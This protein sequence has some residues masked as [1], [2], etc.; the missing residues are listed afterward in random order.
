MNN[1][2]LQQAAEYLRL[3]LPLMARNRVPV[4][5]ENY[6]VWYA[7]VVGANHGLRL[8][9]D[10]IL[11][12]GEGVDERATTMLYQRFLVPW[13]EARAVAAQEALSKTIAG[14]QGSVDNADGDASRYQSAL[15][16]YT[17]QITSDIDSEALRGL[18][19]NLAEETAA[20]R[21][22]GE[23]LRDRLVRSRREIERLR[24]E[25]DRA[26]DEANNDPLTGLLNRQGLDRAFAALPPAAPPAS[27]L[28]IDL[29]RFKRVNNN[30]GHLVGD[31]VLKHIAR[32]LRAGIKG[33]DI[34]AR[35]GGE[36]FVVVLPETPLGGAVTLAENL[37][38]K[39]HHTRLMR[40]EDKRPIGEV[41][42]S[43]GV[44]LRRSDEDLEALIGRADAALYT[45]KRGGR[46]RV[47]SEARCAAAA[48]APAAAPA[49]A[50][51]T[52][53]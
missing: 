34:A 2:T 37:R 18:L 3:T 43:I 1:K 33:G 52:E 46:N 39:I 36:E 14:V 13:D 48:I 27:L 23:H 11:D 15:A 26:H 12:Q 5:P 22:S 30:C 20:M 29:D 45:A 42:V 8:A 41:T 49:I 38:A 9:L 10:E 4:T 53:G 24:E 44:A 21:A 47:V 28:M 40:R 7:Y 32:T 19:G 35:F 31:E 50:T 6:A 17:R 16:E 51:G 25:L